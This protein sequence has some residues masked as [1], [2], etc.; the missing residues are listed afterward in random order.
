ML[1]HHLVGVD[2][3]ESERSLALAATDMRRSAML[4]ADL[5]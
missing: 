1:G 3:Q 2:E 5:E 4:V